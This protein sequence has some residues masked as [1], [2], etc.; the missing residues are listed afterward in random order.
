[1]QQQYS[2]THGTT[3]AKAEVILQDGFKL[4]AGG[5]A[6]HGVYFWQYY[7]NPKI[8]IQLAKAWYNHQ[9]KRQNYGSDKS[10]CAVLDAA[11]K[12]AEQDVLD[13]TGE[14]AEQAWI[15][16]EKLDENSRD[17][18]IGKVYESLISRIEALRGAPILVAKANVSPPPKMNFPLKIAIPFPPIL[19]VRNSAVNININLMALEE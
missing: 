13:C 6:G 15:M 18:D 19:V 9:V 2:G 5:R 14:I 8:A 4:A 12:V 10:P 16:L 11:F 3:S 1:M 7:E 17:D